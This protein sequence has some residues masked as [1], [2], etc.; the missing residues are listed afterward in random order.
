MPEALQHA[1]RRMTGRD[2]HERGRASTP[3]ELLFDLTFV[4]AFG[5]AADELAHALVE[6]HVGEGVVAFVF[7]TFAVSWAWINFSWFASAFDTD[8]RVYRLTTMVQMVGVVVFALGLPAF[9]ASVVH[10]EAVDATNMI[11]GYVVMRVAMLAQWARAAQQD[12]E[13]RATCRSMVVSLLVTQLLWVLM[14]VPELHLGA[15]LPVALVLVA[16]EMAG[17]AYAESR[18]GGT[19][20]H[21]HHIAERY[22]LMVIIALGEGL[23]GTTAALQ[24]LIEEG[25]TVEVAVLAL[26]GVALVFGLWWTYFVLPHGELVSAYRSRSFAWGYGQMVVFGAIV[27]VG[28]GLHAAAYYLEDRHTEL[29]ATGTV[30]SVAVP[31]AAYVAALYV[32]YAVLT[33]SLDPFHWLL[34]AGSAVVVLV[35]V[36][37]SVAGLSMVWC[38]AVLAL[39][40]WVTVVGYETVGHRHNAEVLSRSSNH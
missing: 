16:L 32:L 38:L 18:L 39:T 17:P 22:G 3:L 11:V 37:L 29:S 34:V 31:I 24:P 8:D 14:L 25:W 36:G 7:A 4:I 33:R 20:W 1:V 12:P 28:A 15:W 35:A 30:L 21:G 19:P 40:P 2:P 23:L 26:A 5:T 13:R 6:D 10:H 9:F 27:A